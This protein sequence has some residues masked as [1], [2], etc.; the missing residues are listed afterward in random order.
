ML[1]FLSSAAAMEPDG[2][3]PMMATWVDCCDN[4]GSS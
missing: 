1:C 4:T 2:P 3:A